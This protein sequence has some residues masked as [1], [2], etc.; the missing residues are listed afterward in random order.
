MTT[1]IIPQIDTQAFKVCFNKLAKAK[2]AT[3]I[4]GATMLIY[5]DTLKSLPMWAIEEAAAELQRTPTF[6]F[7][8]AGV[9]FQAGQAEV[10]RRQRENLSSTVREWKDECRSCHDSGW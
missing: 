5:L 4:D 7:P 9:W 10:H 3:D 8:E 2:R 1:A 6:G